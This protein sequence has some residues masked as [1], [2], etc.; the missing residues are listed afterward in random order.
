MSRRASGSIAASTPTAR[1]MASTSRIT[2]I[3]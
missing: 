1:P 2:S 3:M